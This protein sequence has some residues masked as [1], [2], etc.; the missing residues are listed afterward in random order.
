VAASCGRRDLCVWLLKTY[1]Q[2]VNLAE[3]ESGYTA[4]HRSIAHGFINVAV[5][6]I[7]V[8]LSMHYPFNAQ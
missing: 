6:L 7:K 1:A 2:D 4:L 3:I 8:I 5:A